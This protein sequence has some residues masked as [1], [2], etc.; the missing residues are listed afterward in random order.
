MQATL[1]PYE[2]GDASL[3]AE[4]FLL[5]ITEISS[6][7]YTPGQIAAWAKI[8]DLTAWGAVRAS[9]PTWIAEIE[10]HAAGFADLTKDGLVDMMFVHP[11]FQGLGVAS[12][13]LA[14][15]EANANAAGMA[16]LLT[17]ASRTARHFFE[18]RGFQVVQAQQVE[19]RGQM[20]E[21][22]LMEKD[23]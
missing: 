16:R 18:R 7:D 3:T 15:V 4:I 17:E 6:R 21:N 5:A 12:L 8:D 2:W 22:F 9:R 20:L 23:L 19:K 14:E 11:N 10:G 13:L 1:R